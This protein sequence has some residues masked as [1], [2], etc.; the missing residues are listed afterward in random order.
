MY[1]THPLI[2]NK[3]N[4]THAKKKKKKRKG[5]ET[6]GEEKETVKKECPLVSMIRDLTKLFH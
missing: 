4:T 1:K 5:R 3:Y 2:N 6:D